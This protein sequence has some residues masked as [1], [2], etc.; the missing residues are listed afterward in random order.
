MTTSAARCAR[1]CCDVRAVRTAGHATLAAA[2]MRRERAAHPSS[3]TLPARCSRPGALATSAERWPGRAPILDDE[4]PANQGVTAISAPPPAER[5]GHS[6]TPCLSARESWIQKRGGVMLRGM[7]PA[8]AR[9]PSSRARTNHLCRVRHFAR[10]RPPAQASSTLGRVSC[11]GTHARAHARLASACVR[12]P[13]PST[14]QCTQQQRERKASPAHLEVAV[15]GVHGRVLDVVVPQP[16]AAARAHLDA[17][18]GGRVA[19]VLGQRRRVGRRHPQAQQVA[20]LGGVGR[21]LRV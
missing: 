15:L 18:P 8:P 2:S 1:R 10:G 16:V 21:V 14:T 9:L 3:V 17:A 6:H 11:A 4:L 7:E 12:T 13:R 19:A 5:T 20:P